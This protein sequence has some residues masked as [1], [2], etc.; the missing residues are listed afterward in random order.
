[1]ENLN[2]SFFIR[3]MDEYDFAIDDLI[4]SVEKQIPSCP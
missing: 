2:K 4:Q 3:F 1:M